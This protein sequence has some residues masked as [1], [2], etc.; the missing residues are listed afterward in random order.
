MEKHL[1][2]KNYTNCYKASLVWNTCPNIIECFQKSELKPHENRVAFSYHLGLA[3]CENLS[4]KSIN[5]SIGMKAQKREVIFCFVQND[6]ELEY[7][8]GN[9]EEKSKNVKRQ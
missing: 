6:I 5:Q 9:L 1:I 7:R 8:R 2:V 3:W 4:Y